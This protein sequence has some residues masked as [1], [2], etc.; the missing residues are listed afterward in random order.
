MPK[1]M[2]GRVDDTTVRCTVVL[3]SLVM[4]RLQNGIVVELEEPGVLRRYKV[5]PMDDEPGRPPT[6]EE[7][8]RTAGR[9]GP[10]PRTWG[11][12]ASWAPD[13]RTQNGR[14]GRFGH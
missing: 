8:E 12:L 14:Y 6:V 4:A 5:I 9:G 13:P 1:S 3:S 10:P 7:Q 2:N 11:L